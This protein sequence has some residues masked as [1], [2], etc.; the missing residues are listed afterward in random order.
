M[1]EARV[2]QFLGFM[3]A[4]LILP[5]ILVRVGFVAALVIKDRLLSRLRGTPNKVLCLSFI[6]GAVSF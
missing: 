3:I 2:G 6:L 4:A 1:I 5:F